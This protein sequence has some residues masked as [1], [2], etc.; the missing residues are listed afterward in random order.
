MGP[1]LSYD[2]VLAKNHRCRGKITQG[3]LAGKSSL[4]PT[5]PC[6]ELQHPPMCSDGIQGIPSEHM[7]EPGA[8]FY[9]LTGDISQPSGSR[10]VSLTLKTAFGG[11]R[12]A[13]YAS[14]GLR[15]PI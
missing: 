7:G 6:S 5:E 15:R 1:A 12:R 13:A 9:S 4:R 2:T 8:I 3:T 11:Q 14:Q 10:R